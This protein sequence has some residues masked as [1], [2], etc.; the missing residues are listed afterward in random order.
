MRVV[1]AEPETEWLI[2][3]NGFDEFGEILK[4]RSGR[5][6]SE[7]AGFEI[8]GSPSFPHEAHDV[9]RLF[10]QIGINREF[11]WQKSPQAASFFE[12]M[13]ILAGQ[14]GSPRRRARG[15]GAEAEIEQHPFASDTV[16]GWRSHSAIAVNTGMRPG[17]IVS[18]AE[19]N[20]W[21]GGGGA[22]I[23]EGQNKARA[24]QTF[25]AHE[26]VVSAKSKSRNAKSA[27]DN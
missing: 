26:S 22:Q 16:E 8:S 4:G 7:P 13:R 20:V 21:P 1:A 18:E 19:E 9:A 25:E 23:C 5:V 11:L 2:R 6:S 3:R 17:P 12:P 14:H 10:E 27:T 24:Q 15:S